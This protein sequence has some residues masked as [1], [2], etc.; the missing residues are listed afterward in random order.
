MMQIAKPSLVRDFHSR[1]ILTGIVSDMKLQSMKSIVI[2]IYLAPGASQ[3]VSMC[4]CVCVCVCVREW[5]RG[6]VIWK[7]DDRK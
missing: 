3:I 6:N 4:V 7:S 1:K 5:V 2:I